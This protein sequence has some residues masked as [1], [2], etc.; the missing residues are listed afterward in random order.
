MRTRKLIFASVIIVSLMSSQ[1]FGQATVEKKEDTQT[2]QTKKIDSTKPKPADK[3]STK[4]VPSKKYS[5][6]KKKKDVPEVPLANS[7]ITFE[8]T[9]FD[10]GMV[11]PG[12][13]VTYNFQVSNT[14]PDTLNITKIKAG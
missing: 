2:K 8:K 12:N 11:P 13:K 3:A 14:G 4:N 6:Y 9:V 7:R 5:K 10:F 1:V